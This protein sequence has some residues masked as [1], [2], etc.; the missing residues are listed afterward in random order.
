ILDDRPEVRTVVVPVGGGGLIN[1]I[2]QAV[3][4][5]RPEVK[6]FGV[7]AESAAPLPKSLLSG[8]AE[9]VGESKTIA[10]GIR[11]TRVYDYML[12]LFKENLSGAF[13]VTDDELK[14]TMGRLAK[15]SHVVVEPAGAAALAGAMRHFKDL[16]GPIVCVVSGG[17]VDPRLM[18]EILDNQLPRGTS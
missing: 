5:N 1:G 6:F 13:T 8:V 12:P 7:Q 18:R 11:A 4:A 10:D 15:E 14:L 2:A 9:D 3:K 17:N 16:E